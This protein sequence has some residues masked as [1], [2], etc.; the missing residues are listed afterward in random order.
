M[1]VTFT[2]S[3]PASR[4]EATGTVTD[5]STGTPLA[6]KHV[7]QRLDRRRAKGHA[8]GDSQTGFGS[9]GGQVI[10]LQPVRR[11]VDQGEFTA[12]VEPGATGR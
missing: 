11:A 2:V 5:A 1:A 12:A 9:I 10:D 8:E 7:R 4:A 3:T 6:G